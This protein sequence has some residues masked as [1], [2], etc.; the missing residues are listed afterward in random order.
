MVIM[1]LMLSVLVLLVMMMF[2]MIMLMLFK[3]NMMTM[4]MMR[5]AALDAL[6]PIIFCPTPL[7]G[8]PASSMGVSELDH[9]DGNDGC[10]DDH[11]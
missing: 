9:G 6:S 8:T 10:D 4:M 1:T 11:Y 3:M 5:T 7:F 2:A